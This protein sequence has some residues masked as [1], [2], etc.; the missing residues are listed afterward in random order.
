ME[1]VLQDIEKVENKGPIWLLQSGLLRCHKVAKGGDPAML[2]EALKLLEQAKEIR[3]N[4]S[5]IPLWMGQI[6]DQK[7][8]LAQAL[9]FYW[10]AIDLGDYHPV[11]VERTVVVL[12]QQKRYREANDLLARLDREQAPFTLRILK[13]WVELLLQQGEYDQALEKA[14]K[15]A[16]ATA[17][18]DD[19]KDSLFVGQVVDVIAQQTKAADRKKYDELIAEAEKSFRRAVELGQT[20]RKPGSC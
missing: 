14:R 2:D 17:D 5:K 4:W 13:F 6:Y 16:A 9:K 10:D 18:S 3:A 7:D 11:A 15:V 12:Y 20:P 1:K 8:D 19:Y